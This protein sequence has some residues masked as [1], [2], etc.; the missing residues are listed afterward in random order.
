MAA[1]GKEDAKKAIAAANAEAAEYTAHMKVA[2]EANDKK[3]LASVKAA[4][5]DFIA[6]QAALRAAHE[7]KERARKE[8]EARQIA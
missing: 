6:M 5:E 1:K 2:L 4:Q 3:H 7:A 8:L